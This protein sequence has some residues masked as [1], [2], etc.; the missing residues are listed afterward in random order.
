MKRDNGATLVELMVAMVIILIVSLGFFSWLS[1]VTRMNLAIERSNTA[2]AMAN[3]VADR[4]QRM[5]DN[6]LIQAKSGNAKYVGY[7]T[8]GADIGKLRKCDASNDPTIPL[9]V[10]GKPDLTIY[11]NPNAVA[12]K[13]YLY[14]KNACSGQMWSDC[15]GSLTAGNIDTTANANIDHPNAISSV[16]DSINPI[17]SYKGT[18]YYAVWSVA[19]MPCNASDTNRRKI[20]ITVYWID[21][22]PTAATAASALSGTIIKG[23]S[24]VA[25]KTIG[26][27]T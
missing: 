24:L 25:D 11:T 5:N 19:Y 8:S 7:V 17:R 18:T 10:T 20:F 21:P 22:E 14:D 13:L 1:T 3:D 6:A 9:D 4:L 16:Y 12:D 27:E 15:R 23:V 26:A 2:Y